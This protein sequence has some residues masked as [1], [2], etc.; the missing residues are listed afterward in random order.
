M[1]F[2]AQEQNLPG[3][4]MTLLRDLKRIGNGIGQVPACVRTEVM[5]YLVKVEKE[6]IKISPFLRLD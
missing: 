6:W 4:A 5:E 1:E 2:R 3:K